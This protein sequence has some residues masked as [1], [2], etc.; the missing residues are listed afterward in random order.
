MRHLLP[1]CCL[2]ALASSSL[3][4]QPAPHTTTNPKVFTG[5]Y[6]G[7]ATATFPLGR[8]GG[9]I[10]YWRRASDLPAPTVMTATGSRA[11]RGQNAPA[12]ML[13]GVEL[14]M[15]NTAVTFAAFSSTYAANFGAQTTV[16][17]T[18]KPVNLPALSNAIDPDQPV[19][20]L[21]H[22]VPFVFLGP[23]LIVQF[24]LGTAVG[25]TSLGRPA[26][27]VPTAAI[28]HIASAPSCGGTLTASGST[29]LYTLSLQG[30]AANLP[31][32][33]LLGVENV[34][35]GG[36]PVLPYRLDGIGMTG[37][38][39]RLAPAMT[40]SFTADGSGA[41]TWNV[42]INY[43]SSRES[44]IVHAQVLHASPSSPAGWATTNAT[45]SVL[46]NVGLANY[47]YN[48]TADGPVAQYGPYP[49]NRGGILL[50]RP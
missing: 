39:L 12:A 50:F 14:T 41:M 11:T 19:A 7:S 31:G 38:A 42:P 23:H 9:L 18:R 46:G 1:S 5:V 34:L 30:A 32:V 37:C 35:L 15:S 22:D 16:V 33:L 48:Y 21:M 28:T 29:T 4:A 13:N 3:T 24:D 26:D 8:T 17:F 47:A 43:P 45:H 27:S 2:L 40:L 44:D 49:T 25:S 36:A 10:Q 20:W 6:A